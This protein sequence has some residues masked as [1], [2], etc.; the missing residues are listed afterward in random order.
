MSAGAGLPWT[1]RAWPKPCSLLACREGKAL[2]PQLEGTWDERGVVM[3][4]KETRRVWGEAVRDAFW[5]RPS[6]R[7]EL[8]NYE[9]RCST[10]RGLKWINKS[11]SGHQGF[12]LAPEA[13]ELAFCLLWYVSL[14]FFLW[15]RSTLGKCFRPQGTTTHLLILL[16]FGLALFPSR[17]GGGLSSGPTSCVSSAKELSDFRWLR[18]C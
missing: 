17:E 7:R 10:F 1:C 5:C 6:V 16:F 14:K 12:D 9:M 13:I 3:P 18:L 15:K 4:C 8:T 11:L 2:G